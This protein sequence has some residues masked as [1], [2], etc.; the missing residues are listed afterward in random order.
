MTDPNKTLVHQTNAMI[1]HIA[2]K[3]SFPKDDLVRLLKAF[4]DHFQSQIHDE[5]EVFDLRVQD[6]GSIKILYAQT[7]RGRLW[8]RDR[9]SGEHQMWAGGVVVEHRYIDEIINGASEDELSIEF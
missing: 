5:D 1:H 8:V 3:N 4:R 6:E 7:D 9:I 2:E